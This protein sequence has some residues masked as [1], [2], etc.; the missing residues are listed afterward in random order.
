MF[1]QCDIIT[2]Q[3][4]LDSNTQKVRK[5]KICLIFRSTKAQKIG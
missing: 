3:F 4:S 2:R 5:I 1:I